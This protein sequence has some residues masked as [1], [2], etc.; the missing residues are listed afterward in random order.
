MNAS[1]IHNM[2]SRT[3]NNGFGEHLLDHTFVCLNK[4]HLTAYVIFEATIQPTE[5]QLVNSYAVKNKIMN[6]I[7]KI[8]FFL[9]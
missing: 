8:L 6:I 5:L 3:Q 4:H 9:S 1:S 7:A 2:Y